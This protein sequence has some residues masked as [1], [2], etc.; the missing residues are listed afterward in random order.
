MAGA[1]IQYGL[2]SGAE[3]LREERY[4]ADIAAGNGD[5]Q[6]ERVAAI[7]TTRIRVVTILIGVMV[8]IINFSTMLTVRF[9][10]W[11]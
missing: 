2:A 7:K 1:G 8:V 9:F 3:R 6:L 10:A 4:I 11:Y 5:E